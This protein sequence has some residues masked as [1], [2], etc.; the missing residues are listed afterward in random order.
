MIIL[1]SRDVFFASKVT[2]TAQQ[3]GLSAATAM[4]VEALRDWLAG[5][6]VTG[7][8]LDLGS[9]VSAGEVM[10]AVD[11]VQRPRLVAFG[12]HV[13]EAALRS[14]RDAGFDDVLPRSRFSTELVSILRAQ[15]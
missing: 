10:A 4:S 11:S 5:G 12:A 9:G 3:L 1:V 15:R 14:A 13:D 8:I 7:V 2:G 6:D